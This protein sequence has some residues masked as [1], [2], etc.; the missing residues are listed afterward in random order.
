MNK[1][2]FVVDASLLQEL[3]ERLIGRAPIALAELI[4]NSFDADADTCEVEIGDDEIVITDNGEGM[5]EAQFSAF[6]LRIGTTHKVDERVSRGGRP[7]TGSKG[8]GRLSVQ[9]LAQEMILE[10][11]STES[12]ELLLYAVIDWTQVV[13]GK[14]LSTVA[15]DWETRREEGR[16]SQ[17]SPAG[18]RLTLRK[19]KDAWDAS[20]VESLGREV[21]RL[22]S[23]FRRTTSRAKS[24]SDGFEVELN[25]PSIEGAKDAFDRVLTALFGSW[26]ARIRGSLERGRS[27]AAATISVE[28]RAGYPDGAPEGAVYREEASLPVRQSSERKPALVDRTS[29]E[30]LVFKTEGVQ[31]GRI[32]VRELR[33]YLADFGNVSVYDA[34]FRLPYYGSGKDAA[35]HDWLSVALDQGRRLGQSELL[36]ERL[37]AQNKYMQDLPAPGR[38][39]GAVEIDTNH[40]RE[41]ARR[42]GAHPGEWLQIQPGRDRLHDNSAFE[43]LRDLTR[44]ALDFYAT[45]HRLRALAAAE[46]GRS[47]E[48]PSHKYSRLIETIEQN[49]KSIPARVYEVV[50][51]EALDARKAAESE[52]LLVDQR[53]AL[54]APLATAGMAALA[55]SHEFARESRFQGIVAGKLRLLAQAHGLPELV[56]LAGDFD[57]SRNRLEALRSVFSPM[58][59]DVAEAEPTRYRIRTLVSETIAAMRVLMPRVVWDT[60]G[61]DA[62][63]RFPIGTVAEWSAL[64]HNILSNSWNA[65]L[66]MPSAFIA[67]RSGRKGKQREFLRISDSGE[68]LDVPLAESAVLFEPFERRL[69]V[70]KDKQS[71]SLGGQGLGL[72]IVR[73]IAVRRGATVEFVEPES[74]FNTT[75]ELTW[76][77]AAR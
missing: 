36:P 38:I 71:I 35:G 3:G 52:E 12:P 23:P 61:I 13:R 76:K 32:P 66:D 43:Q 65:M 18:T 50:R 53:A 1:D 60:S 57:A 70:A 45:R 33:E 46:R 54:L 55:L 10:S 21:W 14:N 16:Y 68:G 17:G 56:T 48:P 51:A 44:V 30:I 62:E 67:F 9:F 5:S 41:I 37:R 4:K 63:M 73:M 24:S 34:G 31:P 72:A 49:R 26:K 20:A 8:I 19:L 69:T 77:G 28:F 58:S 64:L 11:T 22:R 75:I 39:F 27:G 2:S 59:P 47:K 40:E 7:L 29:F 6:W 15:I 25:A 42:T 74:G